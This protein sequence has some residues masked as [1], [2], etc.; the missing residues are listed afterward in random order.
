MKPKQIRRVRFVAM[1]NAIID[2]GLKCREVGLDISL[3]SAVSINAQLITEPCLGVSMQLELFLSSLASDSE[4]CRSTSLPFFLH[5]LHQ[6][7][8]EGSL[9]GITVSTSLASI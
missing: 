9:P 6:R 7:P 4:K 1:F 8:Q 3:K 2:E 5:L